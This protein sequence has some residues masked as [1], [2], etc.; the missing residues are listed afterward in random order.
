MKSLLATAGTLSLLLAAAEQAQAGPR[1]GFIGMT[2]GT[3]KADP[4]RMVRDH[5]GQPPLHQ[6]TQVFCRRD[7]HGNCHYPYNRIPV[8]RDHRTGQ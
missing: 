3:A 4:P 7:F 2:T 1:E 8:I 6:P 5:R